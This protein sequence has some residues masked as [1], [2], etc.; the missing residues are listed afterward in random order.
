MCIFSKFNAYDTSA[1][2]RTHTHT[3]RA[4]YIRVMGLKKWVSKKQVFKEELKELR[5]RM[6]D[7]NRELVPDNW[8]LVRE[9]V[10]TIGLMQ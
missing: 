5:G 4:L 8:S 2:A 10:L 6:M 9:R 7:R 1:H 3:R